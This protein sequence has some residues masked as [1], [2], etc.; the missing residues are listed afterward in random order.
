MKLEVLEL[1]KHEKD[2]LARESK[3]S[4]FINTGVSE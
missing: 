2:F 4:Q 1:R 3:N